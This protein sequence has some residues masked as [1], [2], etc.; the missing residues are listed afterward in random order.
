V[1]KRNQVAAEA[2][3]RKRKKAGGALQDTPSPFQ[4][5]CQLSPLWQ[6]RACPWD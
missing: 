5:N 4:P 3:T 6:L 2:E 1:G